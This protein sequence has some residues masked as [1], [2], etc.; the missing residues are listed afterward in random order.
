V[1][2]SADIGPAERRIAHEYAEHLGLEHETVDSSVG[3]VLVLRRPKRMP[4]QPALT[5][6]DFVFF[7]TYLGLE[8]RFVEYAAR[9]HLAT[10]PMPLH[11]RS[12][13]EARD[14]PQHHITLLS[15][16]EVSAL[17]SRAANGP[18]SSVE[19]LAALFASLPADWEPLGVGRAAEDEDEVLFVVVFLPA[20][21]FPWLSIT[22]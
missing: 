13:R 17:L 6:T 19:Q 10:L 22:D 3:R 18:T 4:T 15:R 14:G 5:V 12:N 9:S 1:V 11:W 2:L 20:P 21:C 7:K 16:Y 8:G